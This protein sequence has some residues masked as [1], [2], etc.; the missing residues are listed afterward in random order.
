MIFFGYIYNLVAGWFS[1]LPKKENSVPIKCV[2]G[3]R[4]KEKVQPLCLKKKG[5]GLRKRKKKNSRAL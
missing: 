4:E 5:R 3:S 2:R 1:G